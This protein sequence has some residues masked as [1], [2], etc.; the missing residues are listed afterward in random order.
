MKPWKVQKFFEDI[1]Y[2]LRSRGLLPVVILLVVA[3]L[4]VP[5]LISRG[6]SSSS[7]ATLQASAASAQPAPEA[8]NAVVSYTPGVRDYK[9]RLDDATP[10][11]PF[12]QP[13]S[14]APSAA[15]ASQLSSA[16]P[17]GSVS[18]SSAS[19]STSDTTLSGGGS[20][21]SGGSG[22]GDTGKK[23]QKKSSK[24]TYTYSVNVLAGDVT[25]TLTPFNNVA[26][27]TSLPSQT[28]PVIAYYGLSSDYKSALFLVSNKV[29]ALSGPGT[30]V[31]APDDC[32]LL[33]LTPGQT[34]D[35]HYAK[36]GKTYRIVL[37]E[38]KR[39]AK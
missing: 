29:D 25:A 34:E 3:M 7:P 33:S 27:L 26:S 5:I 10:K 4:A 14:S 15:A 11:N 19:G 22:G 2:D 1:A 31:P 9:K 24:T 18:G 21:G 36:D 37:A 32:S 38:I 23:K 39:T 20:G 17:T 8:E 12:R 35:L 16:V 6:G 30:C 13:V 28:T